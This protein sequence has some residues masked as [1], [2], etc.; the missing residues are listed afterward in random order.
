M[1]LSAARSGRRR[2]RVLLA[3]AAALLLALV[4]PPAASAAGAP[5][6]WFSPKSGIGPYPGVADFATLFR[7]DNP[8]WTSVANKIRV[9]SISYDHLARAPDDEVERIATDLRLHHVRW[10]IAI[11]PVAQLPGETCGRGEGYSAPAANQHFVER[12]ARLNVHP[13]QVSIDSPMWFGSL[14]PHKCQFTVAALV[15]H[16][17][18]TIAIWARAFPSA[19][20][21]DIEPWLQL[22]EHPGWQ[23][24]YRAMKDGIAAATGVRLAYVHTDLNDHNHPNWAAELAAVP[25]FVR[26]LGMRYGMIYD[27]RGNDPTDAAWLATAKERIVTAEDRYR[28][29]PDYAVFA[30]WNSHPARALP[31][32]D[33]T[34]LSSLIDFYLARHR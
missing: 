24:D 3:S 5:E 23:A 14:D 18:P 21:G 10:N 20:I 12:L 2:W 22:M 29:I 25:P 15:R 27:G 16:L 1:I 9:Y 34:T 19:T 26:S 8:A 32:T 7:E 33:P 30:T 31:E 6:I 17:A 13:D 11:G 28:I 4:P